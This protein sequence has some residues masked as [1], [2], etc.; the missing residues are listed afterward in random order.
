MT[1]KATRNVRSQTQISLHLDGCEA[2]NRQN[3]NLNL[4]ALLL[5]FVGKKK[6]YSLFILKLLNS[7][8]TPAHTQCHG[9]MLKK[10]CQNVSP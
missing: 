6:K 7:K 1:S 5:N 2:S 3:K 9:W 10:K 4:C 8:E